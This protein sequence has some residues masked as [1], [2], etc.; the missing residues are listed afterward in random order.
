MPLWQCLM[1]QEGRVATGASCAHVITC[2]QA[3]PQ[4]PA[5]T[6]IAAVHQ[7]RAVST[8]DGTAML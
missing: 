3:L 7:D 5:A 1:K 6:C 2:L 4:S 8:L